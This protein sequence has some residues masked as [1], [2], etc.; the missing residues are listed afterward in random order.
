MIS[1]L[2]TSVLVDL[3]NAQSPNHDESRMALDAALVNGTLIISEVVYSELS[4]G[5]EDHEVFERL[6][7]S[8]RIELVPSSLEALHRAGAAWRAYLRQRPPGLS[9]PQ[10]GAA[11][12][13][14]CGACGSEL[15]VRQHLVADF[16]IGAHALVH[17]DRLLTRDRRY[18]AS[19]FPELALP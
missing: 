17:A 13:S 2:D 5:L 15:R 18:Y 19:F 7:E 14:V 12:K 11:Q 6:L 8:T 3:L 4:A 10:C 9:C 1:A 16:M